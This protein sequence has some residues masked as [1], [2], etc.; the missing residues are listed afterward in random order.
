M[1][2]LIV[3]LRDLSVF[4]YMYE[5]YGGMGWVGIY[6][7]GSNYMNKR[8]LILRTFWAIASKYEINLELK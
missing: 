7:D 6:C 3:R 5:R 8:R 1:H 4:N 2:K